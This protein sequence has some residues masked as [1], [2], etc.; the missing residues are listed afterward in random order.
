MRENRLAQQI[1][2]MTKNAKAGENS[3]SKALKELFIQHLSKEAYETLMRTLEEQK[4]DRGVVNETLKSTIVAKLPL[5]IEALHLLAHM[6]ADA[7]MQN[8][9]QQHKIPA[10][11]ILKGDMLPSDAIREKWVGCAIGITH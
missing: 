1:E 9:T 4:A 6:R 3:Y 2:A 8:M 7:I 10:H 5:E 11:K